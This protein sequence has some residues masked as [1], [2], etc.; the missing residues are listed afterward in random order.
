MRDHQVLIETL[1]CGTP[2]EAVEKMKEHLS[3]GIRQIEV[4]L[5][6]YFRIRKIRG[7]TYS[8][9]PEKRT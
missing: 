1:N 3:L 9:T 7:N 5:Q 8:R 6:P 2:E 4:G